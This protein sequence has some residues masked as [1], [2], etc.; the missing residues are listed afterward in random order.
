MSPLASSRRQVVATVQEVMPRV[1]LAF[2]TDP[3]ERLWGITRSMPGGPLDALRAGMKVRLTVEQHDRHE[4][5][6][7]WAPLA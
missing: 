5:P 4:V 2:V 7:D 6:S 3:D 1:G